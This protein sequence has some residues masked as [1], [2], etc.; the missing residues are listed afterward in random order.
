MIKASPAGF[1]AELKVGKA[2]KVASE[3]ASSVELKGLSVESIDVK[4]DGAGRVTLEGKL[5][6]DIGGQV[7]EVTL[8][9]TQTSKVET[10]DKSFIK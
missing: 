9:Q 6:I 4:S 1:K 10:S 2:F 7:T 3:G 8:N 5:N